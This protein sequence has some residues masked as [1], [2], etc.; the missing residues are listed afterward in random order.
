MPNHDSIY[1]HEAD[2]YHELIAKQPDLRSVVEELAP[3]A[4]ADI[5]DLGAGTGRLSAALAP[6]ARSLVA[7]DASEAM[8][9]IAADRL[10]QAGLDNW[11]VRVADHRRLPLPDASADLVV[12]GW[13]VCYLT[14]DSVPDWEA[15]LARIV[16]EM[17]R[18]LRPGGTIVLFETMGTG[19]ETPSPPGFLLPYFTR[20]TNEYRFSHRWLRLDYAFD[21]AAQA[22]RL[23]RF[24][25]G[26]ELADW[27]ARDRLVRL[28]ECAGVWRLRPNQIDHA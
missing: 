2:M 21:D 11:S 9:R 3:V 20:L 12:S 6:G 1:R 4:G 7:L 19:H 10:R 17:K 27:V 23:T 16:A 22:E 5:V 26:D 24:F 8:L 13:S 18:V 25:F 15:N 28:P 14:A